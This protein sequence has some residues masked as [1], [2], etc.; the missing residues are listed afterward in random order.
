MHNFLYKQDF[1]TYPGK[2]AMQ[3][4]FRLANMGAITKHDIT[5]FLGYLE[6]YVVEKDIKLRH[7]QADKV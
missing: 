7:P 6:E 4:T 2:G 5:K 3:N 1:T